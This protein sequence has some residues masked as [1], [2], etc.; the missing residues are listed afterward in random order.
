MA[1]SRQHALL[2]EAMPAINDKVSSINSG[3]CGYYELALQ[4]ALKG[5]GIKSSIVIVNMGTWCGYDKSDVASL[6][7]DTGTKNISDAWQHV[8]DN[9][10][11]HNHNLCNGHICVKVGR[12]VYDSKGL[13]TYDIISGAISEQAMEAG[14]QVDQW[15]NY[16]LRSN[17]DDLA[18][19][20]AMFTTFLTNLFKGVAHA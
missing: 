13:Q 19:V 8:F 12:S 20:N 1:T 10:T 2:R 4:R 18:H 14:L 3:G 15:N 16:F 6:M 5:A 9:G 17:S 11:G 7:R